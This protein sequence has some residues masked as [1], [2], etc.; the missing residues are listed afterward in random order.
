MT[1]VPRH[2][3]RDTQRTVD[4]T[5]IG[6]TRYKATNQRGGVLP[7]GSGDDPDFTPVELLLAAIAG[8][9][10]ID[11]DLITGKRSRPESFDVHV[12]GDKIRDEDGNHLTN[13]RVVFDVTFPG[14]EGGDAAR[15]VLQSAIEKSRDRICTVSR[16]VALPTPVEMTQREPGRV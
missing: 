5:R 14:G 10:A 6:D 16:T 11:V 8:C 4:L 12:E 13:L 2:A 9:S 15:G 3:P 7:I 1:E